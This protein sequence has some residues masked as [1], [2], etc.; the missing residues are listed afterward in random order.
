MF[1]S[2]GFRSPRGKRTRTGLIEAASCKAVITSEL[3]DK[4]IRRAALHDL[5]SPG[6]AADRSR[7]CHR[8]VQAGRG[9]ALW[10]LARR[11]LAARAGAPDGRDAR[12][13][14]DQA[15][16]ARR[17]HAPHPARGRH[18]R[19]RGSEGDPRAAVLGCS[20]SRST[21][22]TARRRQRSPLGCMKASR[23]RQ[24]SPASWQRTPAFRL[25]TFCC[26]RIFSGF[27]PS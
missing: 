16:A 12:G 2:F 26:R 9:T 23:S 5:Q 19:G 14:G 17:G 7:D 20:W 3:S 8:A 25:P 10:R 27:A 1:Q 22:A 6:A 15:V 4:A 11:G 24:N 18:R 13:T 21:P